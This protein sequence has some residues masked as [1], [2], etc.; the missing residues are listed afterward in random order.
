LGV[1]LSTYLPSSIAEVRERIELIPLLPLCAF[2]AGY[3]VNSTFTVGFVYEI[4]KS[5]EILFYTP[6]L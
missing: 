2:M 4:F 5:V 3:R 1:V 6:R